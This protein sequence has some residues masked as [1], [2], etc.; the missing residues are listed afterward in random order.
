MMDPCLETLRG[1]RA[2]VTVVQGSRDQV[3][4]VECSSNIKVKVPDAEVKIIT[5]ANHTTVIVGR[6]KQ[7]AAELELIW[8]SVNDAKG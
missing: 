2:Q 1:V 8:D 6:E 3:V 5:G 4:P 7:L